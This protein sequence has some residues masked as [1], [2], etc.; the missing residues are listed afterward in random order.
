M[1]R[2]NSIYWFRHSLRL[3]D[4]ESFLAA[5]SGSDKLFPIFIFDHSKFPQPSEDTC[6][7]MGI[8]RHY[9]LND[10]LSDLD[11]Q[12]RKMGSKLI[13][14]SGDPIVIVSKICSLWSIKRLLM[15]MSIGSY[16]RERDECVINHCKDNDIDVIQ[17]WDQLLYPM[18]SY[19]N[20]KPVK[21]MNS[22]L[23]LLPNLQEP[24]KPTGFP[25]SIP[26]PDWT[27]LSNESDFSSDLCN[28]NILKYAGG[29]TVALERM[30]EVLNDSLW[31]SNFS[32]PQTSPNSLEPSTTVLS[33]Y[34]A[35]GCISPKT[36]WH[37]IQSKIGEKKN[38]TQPPVSLFGQLYWREFFY[39]N[40]WITPNFHQML[41]NRSCKQIDWDCNESYLH[42]WE[43]S[44]TGYPFI[45]A[46]MTQL[47]EE[48]WIHHLARHAV[49]C[50]L[51]RGD[52]YQ[53]WEK[54]AKVF[55]KYLLD[56]DYALNNANW[57]WLS[58]SNFFYQ[59]H[60]VYSPIT[61]GKKTDPSGEYIRKWLPQLKLFPNN[62]IY[63][64]WIAPK[65]IQVKAKCI[66][67]IDY[68]GPIVDHENAKKCNMERMK[69]S[70][71][72][73]KNNASSISIKRKRD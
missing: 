63:E 33:P 27:L 71:G 2:K 25:D 37:K 38:C 1:G 61:F 18:E 19:L 52:L 50:F 58:C 28:K 4:N 54:G 35:M 20:F 12:L 14:F 3:A 69:S 31:I 36:I 43:Y 64:P 21:T 41:G 70:Y 72:R 66:I 6:Y 46:I 47:R 62:Y 34:L 9:F 44:K 59:Y 68:P 45:D 60:R 5:I 26:P 8:N 53:S 32:K 65:A 22:Y 57:Q 48:G 24:L 7:N 56:G 40:A 16:G 13:V 55:E 30:E 51:T 42:A 73:A 11:C 67:G 29:E 10:C 39:I 17:Y 23:S 15:S 49:A